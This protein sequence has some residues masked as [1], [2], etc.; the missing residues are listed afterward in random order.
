MNE[1]GYQLACPTGEF[2]LVPLLMPEIYISMPENRLLVTIME[3]ICVNRTAL[4]LL[5][6]VL[7]KN[8]IQNWF[9]EK[10]TGLEVVTISTTRY[11]NEEICSTQLDYFIKHTNSRPDKPQKILLINSTTYYESPN[12]ILKA[13]NNYIW[14]IK[15]IA[16]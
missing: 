9:H 11:T 1:K 5:V 13:K 10:M 3:C 8:I 6:I 15:F 12:F 2:V 4:L 7:G 14:I 16:H